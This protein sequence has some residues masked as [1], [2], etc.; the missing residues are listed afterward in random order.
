MNKLLLKGH[1][2][3]YVGEPLEVIVLDRK[4]NW[5][6]VSNFLLDG[7]KEKEVELK[8]LQECYD[9]LKFWVSQPHFV[10]GVILDY[11][12]QTV[13]FNKFEAME[14]YFN[15]QAKGEDLRS[16]FYKREPISF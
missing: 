3:T 8:T 10:F 15:S 16:Y 12:T 11:G 4:N 2:L 7:Q 5:S 14:C 6:T 1:E 13:Y 9:Y